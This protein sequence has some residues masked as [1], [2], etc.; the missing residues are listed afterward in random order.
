MPIRFFLSWRDINVFCVA[1][2]SLKEGLQRHSD[3]AAAVLL[4][5]LYC[6]VLGEALLHISPVPSRSPG[7]GYLG[8]TF[9]SKIS[10]A[11]I[12]NLD[13]TVYLVVGLTSLN[14]TAQGHQAS[15]WVH[16]R[17]TGRTTANMLLQWFCTEYAYFYMPVTFQP[18]DIDDERISMESVNLFSKLKHA[19][20]KIHYYMKYDINILLV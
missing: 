4:I 16:L 9:H 6:T 17:N 8:Y 15:A 7:Y 19:Y 11:I 12:N 13:Y 10:P 1:G 3:R 18:E 14:L 20:S 5:V 2:R